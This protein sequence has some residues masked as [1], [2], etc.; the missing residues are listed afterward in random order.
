MEAL[1]D[2]VERAVPD[3]LA[4]RY[5]PPGGPRRFLFSW[6]RKGELGGAQGL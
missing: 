2:E 4:V 6:V 3:T 1:L 5:L